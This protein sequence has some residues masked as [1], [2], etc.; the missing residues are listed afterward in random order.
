MML[1]VF[2]NVFSNSIYIVF[3]YGN[4][5]KK[6]HTDLWDVLSFILPNNR[7]TCLVMGDFNA[8]FLLVIKNIHSL[9]RRCNHFRNFV[10]SCN[11]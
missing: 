1:R 9:G 3:V 11:L 5:N 8:V 6:K 4:T 7:F 2:D 10:K